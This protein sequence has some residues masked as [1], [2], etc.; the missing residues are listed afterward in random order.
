MW[1][2]YVSTPLCRIEVVIHKDTCF[3]GRVVNVST[4]LCRIEV[5]IRRKDELKRLWVLYVSTPLCRI[6]VVILLTG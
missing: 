5:V 2:L 4:P 6:E 1:V 3:G